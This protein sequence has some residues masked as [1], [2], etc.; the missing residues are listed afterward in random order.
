MSKLKEATQV[1]AGPPVSTDAWGSMLKAYEPCD[2]VQNVTNRD[3]RKPRSYHI[4][5][6]IRGKAIIPSSFWILDPEPQRG[7]SGFT[8][9]SPVSQVYG[10]KLEP[11]RA[12]FFGGGQ[13][14]RRR[15]PKI[16]RFSWW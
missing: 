16:R 3:L 7:W 6:G 13:N 10:T 1:V 4:L 14:R 9:Q 15:P 8:K 2:M 5:S 12:T 11:M